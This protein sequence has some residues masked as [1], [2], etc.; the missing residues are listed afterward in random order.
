MKRVKCCS[1]FLL[2]LFFM[3]CS[4]LESGF[5]QSSSYAPVFKED[6]AVPLKGS[7]AKLK[8][9]PG[10]L[11]TYHTGKVGTDNFV[12]LQAHFAFLQSGYNKALRSTLYDIG[13]K[14]VVISDLCQQAT[15]PKTQGAYW[16]ECDPPD[17]TI[18]NEEKD[19]YLIYH[20]KKYSYTYGDDTSVENYTYLYNAKT[21]K[22]TLLE[23]MFVGTED[24]NNNGSP[25]II[26]YFKKENSLPTA[27]LT[28][29]ALETSAA[30]ELMIKKFAS[31]VTKHVIWGAYKKNIP[32]SEKTFLSVKGFSG[33]VKTQFVWEEQMA[34]LFFSAKKVPREEVR[35]VCQNM[36]NELYPLYCNERS[37]IYSLKNV[38]G[39][40]QKTFYRIQPLQSVKEHRGGDYR[41]VVEGKG[42]NI[43]TYGNND[44]LY[45]KNVYVK[46]DNFSGLRLKQTDRDQMILDTFSKFKCTE[47]LIDNHAFCSATSGHQAG[48]YKM[49]SGTV[50]SFGF[51]PD[52]L[53]FA[54]TKDKEQHYTL[55]INRNKLVFFSGWMGNLGTNPRWSNSDYRTL[56]YRDIFT[57][58]TVL[59]YDPALIGLYYNSLFTLD[60]NWNLHIYTPSVAQSGVGGPGRIE[61]W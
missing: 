1:V 42:H 44:G 6:A 24:L 48:E 28:A 57:T 35:S 7:F 5:S 22:A 27:D 50:L 54:A 52:F 32:G 33:P 23:G 26:T 16:A 9:I 41:P 17:I 38:F 51:I 14:K 61:K 49:G 31:G 15:S 25:E 59:G 11:F 12:Q 21:G 60:D 55:G 53:S 30:G 58:E 46:F 10:H 47:E 8:E 3:V 56:R 19:L 43:G 18:I 29:F 36:N 2:V 4:F 13:K 45:P 39:P 34:S 20:N 40:G 37:K